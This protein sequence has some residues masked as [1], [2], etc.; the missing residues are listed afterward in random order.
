MAIVRASRNTL[1]VLEHSPRSN[2]G[3]WHPHPGYL[4]DG[5]HICDILTSCPRLQDLSISIPTMCASLFSNHS[6]RWRGE[7]QVRALGLCG[8]D[9]YQASGSD[10][11]NSHAAH[12]ALRKVL[13]A[14]RG[15]MRV[16]ANGT[17]PDELNLEIFFADM[18][19][20]PVVHAVHGDFAMAEMISGGTW[21]ARKKP[22]RK[23]PYGSTGL[24]GKDFSESARN[25]VEGIEEAEDRAF[26]K[27]TEDEVWAGLGRGLLRL[28]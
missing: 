16:R 28:N 15:L 17:I 20:D 19:F 13:S 11:G 1:R 18:I 27:I 9:D 26:T 14:A 22:S 3:F 4:Q 8:H 23:G 12:L 2:D 5:A 6:V 24:Y 10:C 7:C 21:P 25:R